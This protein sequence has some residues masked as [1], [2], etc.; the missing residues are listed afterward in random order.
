MMQYRDAVNPPDGTKPFQ[1]PAQLFL[2]GTFRQTHQLRDAKFTLRAVQ[3]HGHTVAQLKVSCVLHRALR[4][5]TSFKVEVAQHIGI[6]C[7]AQ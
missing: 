3:R 2:D 5:A 4:L 7:C 6:T 1:D